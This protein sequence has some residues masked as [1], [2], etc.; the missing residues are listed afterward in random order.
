MCFE[1]EATLKLRNS[2]LGSV[3]G[4]V[5]QKEALK[6]RETDQNVGGYT[7]K[8]W[9]DVSFLDL[10]VDNK[11]ASRQVCKEAGRW[12]QLTQSQAFVQ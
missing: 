3:A 12:R 7:V 4:I 2:R 6:L 5:G 1:P 8:K 9:T 10:M 11:N